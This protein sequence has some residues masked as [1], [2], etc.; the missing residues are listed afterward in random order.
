MVDAE[1]DRRLYER[2][3][4]RRWREFNRAGCLSLSG[5]Q[6]PKTQF[7]DFLIRRGLARP[8]ERLTPGQLAALVSIVLNELITAEL[9]HGDSD[10][11]APR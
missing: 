3:R 6:V 11:G 1:T 9:S 4:K 10:N 8:G 2:E 5:V 7:K